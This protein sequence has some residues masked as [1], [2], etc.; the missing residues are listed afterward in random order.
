MTRTWPCDKAVFKVEFV[1]LIRANMIASFCSLL[2]EKKYLMIA[3][4]LFYDIIVPK[5][6]ALKIPS[7]TVRQYICLSGKRYIS[8]LHSMPRNLM[9]SS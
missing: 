6:K 7:S 4:N 5:F 8:I 1:A 3:S 2:S 9:N